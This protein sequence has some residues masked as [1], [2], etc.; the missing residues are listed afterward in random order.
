MGRYNPVFPYQAGFKPD[1]AGR[2]RGLQKAERSLWQWYRITYGQDADEFWFDVPLDGRPPAAGLAPS[3]AAMLPVKYRR[4]WKT[5]TSKRADAIGRW[6][7]DYRIIEL[8][9]NAGPE[10]VGEITTYRTLAAREY[11]RLAFQ[12]P[13]LIT[14]AIDTMLRQVVDSANILMFVR[15]YPRPA[16]HAAKM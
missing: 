9:W 8:R 10:T 1:W 11:P 14:D 4:L 2:P 13:I 3:P 12:S 5:V 6:G 16:A 15:P 7:G